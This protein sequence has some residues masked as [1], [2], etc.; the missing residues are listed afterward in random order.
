MLLT[1]AAAREID[2]Q[3]IEAFGLPGLVLMENAGR[4]AAA[5]I[6]QFAV[7]DRDQVFLILVGPGNNGGDGLVIA[8]HLDNAGLAVRVVVAAEPARFRGDAAVNLRVVERSG[9]RLDW[10]GDADAADLFPR[11]RD[12]LAG[13]TVVVD[14]L[15]GTGATAAARGRIAVAITAVTAWRAEQPHRRVVAIDLPSGLDCD[16]GAALGPCVH[17]DLTVSFVAAKAGF[18]TPAAVALLGEVRTVD[19]GVPRAVL[20]AVARSRADG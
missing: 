9:I 7:P 10:L 17:A 1:R 19:I 15:L 18:A 20:A 4:N 2:R 11:L 16:T 5:E 8:R 13:G 14:A 12:L 3:A 6:R